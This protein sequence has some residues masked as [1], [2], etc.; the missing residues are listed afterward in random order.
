MSD[1]K[2]YSHINHTARFFIRHG[3][4]KILTISD[5]KTVA[6]W[7]I[8]GLTGPPC[9]SN[10]VT[11]RKSLIFSPITQFGEAKTSIK[12]ESSCFKKQRN[13]TNL[14]ELRLVIRQMFCTCSG[15]QKSRE[16]KPGVL[17]MD[18]SCCGSTE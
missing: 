13:S 5:Y 17:K 16:V 7:L 14:E 8:K 9:Q 10:L 18:Y 3:L 4:E 12:P 15:R 1:C 2:L 6:D 11:I